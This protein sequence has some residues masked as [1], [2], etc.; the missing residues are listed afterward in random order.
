MST[1]MLRLAA[2]GTFTVLALTGC[3]G[4]DNNTGDN[5]GDNNPPTEQTCFQNPADVHNEII[6]SCPPEGVTKLEKNPVL[7]MN[8]D[9]TLPSLP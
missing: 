6:N 9:G 8:A 7:P 3:P 1:R 5:G 2:A 4:P